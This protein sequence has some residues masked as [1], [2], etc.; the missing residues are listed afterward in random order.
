LIAALGHDL[1]HQGTNNGYEIK[2]KT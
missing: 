1:K 2:M